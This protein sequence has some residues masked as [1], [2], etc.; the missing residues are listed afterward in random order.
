MIPKF[1]NTVLL[2]LT[3]LV[4]MT[5][6]ARAADAG[7]ASTTQPDLQS[8]INALQAEVQ[9]LK[10][11]QSTLTP[12]SPSTAPAGGATNL[13]GGWN[14][15]LQQFYIGSTDGNFYFHPGIIFQGRYNADWHRSPDKW[16]NGFE[17]RC[18]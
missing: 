17:L 5:G 11:Q 8:Q 13:T 3:S 10:S 2:G 12:V 18:C 7:A 4:W 9:D 6:A 15:T 1:T 14:P 16:T